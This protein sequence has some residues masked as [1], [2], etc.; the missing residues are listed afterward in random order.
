MSESHETRKSGKLIVKNFIK[1]KGYSIEKSNIVGCDIIMKKDKEIFFA[2]I[3][4]TEKTSFNYR[5]LEESQV[6]LCQEKKGNFLLFLVSNS[7]L[8]P[9]IYG[10]YDGNYLLKNIK[11]IVL[12]TYFDVS[13]QFMFEI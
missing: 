1:E 12:H 4:T 13:S 11:N 7:K 10:L 6:K 8:E 2:L 3:K 5:W 9:K